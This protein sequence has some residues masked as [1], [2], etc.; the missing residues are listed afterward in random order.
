MSA[1]PT[2]PAETLISNV[3]MT[4]DWNAALDRGDWCPM[5]EF[6]V[7]RMQ[8]AGMPSEAISGLGLILKG[9]EL[10]RPFWH[11]AL[12]R[13][14]TEEALLC[15]L[16]TSGLKAD[17]RS[18]AEQDGTQTAGGALAKRCAEV[19]RLRAR[20]DKPS[21]PPRFLLDPQ[22]RAELPPYYGRQDWGLPPVRR[23]PHADQV[24]IATLSRHLPSPMGPCRVSGWTQ[25]EL[26]AAADALLQVLDAW[27]SP[28]A[29]AD[30]F[31]AAGWANLPGHDCA[32]EDLPEPASAPLRPDAAVGG[33]SDVDWNCDRDVLLAWWGRIIAAM[34][35]R[36]RRIWRAYTLPKLLSSAGIGRSGDPPEQAAIA[37]ELG[38]SIQTVSAEHQAILEH[39]SQALPSDP[40]TRLAALGIMPLLLE[41]G[42]SQ[43]LWE[44]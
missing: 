33:G 30:A 35:A 38:V 41:C 26:A 24:C 19:L 18:Q 40:G 7:L 23:V 42:S 17:R 3:R 9:S 1:S 32:L 28:G 10:D 13:C 44:Q 31:V 21:S 37:Q 20:P 15:Y 16:R 36:Q 11:K 4:F 29:C 2:H 34:N 22:P 6:A 14:A 25:P 12:V 39:L 5:V 8:A 43:P 27:T